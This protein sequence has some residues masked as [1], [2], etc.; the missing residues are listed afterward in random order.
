MLLPDTDARAAVPLVERIEE[1]LARRVPH[2]P[3]TASSPEDGAELEQLYRVADAGLYA[4]KF[5]RSGRAE[6]RSG[7]AL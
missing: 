7:A 5:A 2:S 3:G 4:R 6:R 1:R